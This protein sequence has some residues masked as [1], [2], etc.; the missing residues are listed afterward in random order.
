MT[1][2]G[3]GQLIERHGAVV[4]RAPNKPNKNSG[5]WASTHRMRCSGA[6]QDSPK[7]KQ[8]IRTREQGATECRSTAAFRDPAKT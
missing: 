8:A 4:G 5:N 7:A 1:V 3:L 2:Q 6:D